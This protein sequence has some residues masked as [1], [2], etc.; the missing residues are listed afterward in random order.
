MKI[1]VAYSGLARA[2]AGRGAEEFELPPAADL[3]TLLAEV[4]RRHGLAIQPLLENGPTGAPPILAFVGEQQVD[5]H[6]PA[7]LKDG[8]E[9]MLL[10]PIAGG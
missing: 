5:W 8:D 4:A 7:P 6:S 9:V 2:A 3:R 1:K 10:S